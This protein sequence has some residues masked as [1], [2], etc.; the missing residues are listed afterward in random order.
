M[1]D[2]SDTPVTHG[3]CRLHRA[4]IEQRFGTVEHDMAEVKRSMA[5]V[6]ADVGIMKTTLSALSDSAAEF[7]ASIMGLATWIA[8]GIVLVLVLVAAGRG[9][10]L[11]SIL[12]G[13]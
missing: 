6:K 5:E 12:G 10:D 11:T 2:Q 1:T 8:R 4:L 7:Q 13:I 3:E 9:L